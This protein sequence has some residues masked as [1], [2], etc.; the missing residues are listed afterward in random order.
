MRL[1][2]GK[3]IKWEPAAL[4]LFVLGMGL[5]LAMGPTGPEM[6]PG[7]NKVDVKI[8]DTRGVLEATPGLG[9]GGEPVFR[10]L[11]SL[12]QHALSHQPGR[13]HVRGVIHQVQRLQRRIGASLAYRA[14]FA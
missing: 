11:P 12:C 5:W 9:P 2:S 14:V 4:M 6:R 1:K 13:F 10:L 8:G 7:S 3:R